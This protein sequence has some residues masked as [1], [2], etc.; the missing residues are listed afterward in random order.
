MADGLM[1]TAQWDMLLKVRYYR[2]HT[3]KYYGITY[4]MI[5]DGLSY[6]GLVRPL[7]DR[8]FFRYLDIM[9]KRKGQRYRYSH[10][11]D[12]TDS[13]MMRLRE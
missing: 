4:A 5:Y 1:N 10:G 9:Q 3:R 7:P 13:F 12:D 6:K 8:V 11:E 2:C